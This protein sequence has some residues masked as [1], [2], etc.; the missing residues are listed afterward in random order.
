MRIRSFTRSIAGL[1]FL[2]VF[3]LTAFAHPALAQSDDASSPDVATSPDANAKH[4]KLRVSPK[5]PLKFGDVT[6]GTTSLPQTV[7][8]INTSNS[9]AIPLSSIRVKLPFI[10]VKIGTTCVLGVPAGGTC[11]ISIAFK[12][13]VE[14]SVALNHGLTVSGAFKNSPIF[15]QLKGTGENGPTPTPATP[16]PSGTPTTTITATPSPTTTIGITPSATPTL[17]TAT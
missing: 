14:G 12:P 9:K 10:K 11:D 17:T 3:L 15:Y 7:T 2:L 13:T 6:V 5:E 16:T 4:P 1:A 8:L